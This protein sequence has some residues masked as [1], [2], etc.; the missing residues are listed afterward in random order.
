MLSLLTMHFRGMRS[1]SSWTVQNQG[2]GQTDVPSWFDSIFL[3][4]EAALDFNFATHDGAT[5]IRINDLHLASIERSGGLEAGES[6]TANARFKLPDDAIGDFYLS[7]Y[8][9]I[10][11]GVQQPERGDVYEFNQELNNWASD[12]IRI[13]LTPPPDLVVT[14]IE[15]PASTLSGESVEL[16]WT[17]TNAGPGAT[18]EEAW[19]DLVYYS[20]TPVFDAA[21]AVLL[22]SF[23]HL[24]VLSNDASYTATASV[25]V[26]DGA[27]G[28]ESFFVHTNPDETVFEHTSDDNNVNGSAQPSAVTRSPYPDL[29]ILG[30]A[31]SPAAATAG[32]QV[33]VSYE[34]ANTGTAVADAW[35]DEIYVSDNPQWDPEEA[36]RV[37]SVAHDG[38]MAPDASHE[39]STAITLP[40]ELDDSYYVFVWADAEDRLFEFPDEQGNVFRSAAYTVETYPPVDLRAKIVSSP[41]SATSGASV[42]LEIR[43]RNV[44]VGRTTAEGWTDEIYLS[45]DSDLNAENDLLLDRTFHEGALAGARNTWFARMYPCR[46]G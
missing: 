19:N 26:P 43:V 28:A 29:E 32:Q 23:Q 35:T 16:S 5:T 39:H 42:E 13:T 46:T 21:R 38:E 10:P 12:S 45:E 20:P 3:S 4:E 25:R 37:G 22:G 30:I 41:G 31:V 34:V 14:D 9:D 40:P 33:A 15:A 17:V 2:S 1:K 18:R 36:L 24:G 6:Y 8:T 11:A 7:V 27:N 44:G